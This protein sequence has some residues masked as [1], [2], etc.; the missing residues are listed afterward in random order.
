MKAAKLYNFN[1][2][3]IEDIPIPEIGPGDALIRTHAC[4]ICSGDVMPWYIEKKALLVIGH[5]PTGEIVETGEG[6]TSFKPGDR[7]FTHHHA[8]CFT[9]R[10]CRCGDYVQCETWKN[11]KIIPGG[12]SEYILIPRINLEND[13]L[14][15]PD[16]LS[17]EDGTLIEPTA[18]VVKALK[19]AGIRRGDTVLVIG[20]GFMGQL[21]V[22]LARKYGAGKIIGADMVQFRLQKAKESGADEMID[23]S[24]NNLIEALKELTNGEMADVVIVGPNSAEAMKQGIGSTGAGG[25]VLFFTPAK[26]DEKLILDPNEL[27][28]KDINIITSYSCGPTDTADALEIIES[29]I[30]SAEKLV[31]HRFPIEKT[32]EA[33]RLTAEAKDSF[34]SVIV[35]E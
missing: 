32:A 33:F 26:P 14:S 8:P 20:L 4:G 2:I 28:F 27:Y 13:T 1:D 34:K 7:V 3:R 21:N 23:V 16:T 5:E 17:Y 12:I 18:C 22:L 31:T 9:C 25:K 11:T 6:V 24:K 19:R 29:G 30:V 35:F 15:L 10:F